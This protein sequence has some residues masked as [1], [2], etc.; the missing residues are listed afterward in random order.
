MGFV[1][2]VQYVISEKLLPLIKLGITPVI[3]EPILEDKNKDN[4]ISALLLWWKGWTTQQNLSNKNASTFSKGLIKNTRCL[5]RQKTRKVISMEESST[6][7]VLTSR[8]LHREDTFSQSICEMKKG[9]N[10]YKVCIFCFFGWGQRS[11][12]V[13]KNNSTH[14]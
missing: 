8:T 11:T 12:Q 5:L 6:F 4:F 1:S 3:S 7:L 13:V 9:H 2:L 14:V 10:K